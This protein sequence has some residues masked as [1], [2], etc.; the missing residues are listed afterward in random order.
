MNLDL[1]SPVLDVAIGLSFVFF[2]LSLVVSA[3]TELTSWIASRRAANLEKALRS[4]LGN[5]QWA[6]AILDHPL[7]Q[8]GVRK[9]GQRPSYISARNF[10]LAFLD[11]FAPPKGQKGT[12]RRVKE[13]AEKL[14]E[15][16]VLKRQVIA[17]LEDA[18]GDVERFRA[19]VEAW[20]NDT[21]DRVSGWYRRWAQAIACVI[22]AVVAIGLNVD[23]LRVADRLANDQT[24]RE[25][26]VAQ[27]Q[28]TLAS[29]SRASTN[30]E[31]PKQ[32]GEGVQS[33]TN[34]I[35]ALN[36]PV[37]WNDAN[38]QIDLSTFVGW[39]LTAIAISLGAPFWFDSLSKLSNLRTTGAKPSTTASE[40]PG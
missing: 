28:Q 7:I 6:T 19:S 1:G 11:V 37:G 38:D 5:E 20:F 30:P 24:V 29:Q 9:K 35:G 8:A 22:A 18:E 16:S 12:L 25:A 26:V 39:L 14:D 13:E 17:L 33:A 32:A 4:L 31:S 27:A 40:V 36:L 2:L 23:T 3:G 10:S 21:M 15:S 34:E